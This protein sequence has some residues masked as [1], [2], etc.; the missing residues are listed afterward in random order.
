MMSSAVV[1][2]FFIN[3]TGGG[4]RSRTFIHGFKGRCPAVRRPPNVSATQLD[5]IKLLLFLLA[6]R[7]VERKLQG[8]LREGRAVHFY[9]RGKELGKECGI[10]RNTILARQA[11]QYF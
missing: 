6:Q 11:L 4:G 9:K 1:L 3:F 5:N 7:A 8:N 10:Y 2:S